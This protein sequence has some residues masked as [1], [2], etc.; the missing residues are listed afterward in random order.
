M[1]NKESSCTE[2]VL[3]MDLCKLCMRIIS[4]VC[5]SPSLLCISRRVGHQSIS[6]LSEEHI[7]VEVVA[8]TSDLI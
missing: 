3:Y 8:K 7:T 2:L 1:L 4:L 5:V 6:V